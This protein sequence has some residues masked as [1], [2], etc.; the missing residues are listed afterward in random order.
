MQP[1]LCYT[2]TPVLPCLLFL[3]ACSSGKWC[4]PLR[5]H[6]SDANNPW[7]DPDFFLASLRHCKRPSIWT[8][9]LWLPLI[10]KKDTTETD[11]STGPR[12]RH[13]ACR[14]AYRSDSPLASTPIWA[15]S[16]RQRTRPPLPQSILDC[17]LVWRG[18]D[19]MQSCCVTS[20]HAAPSSYV[21]C[22]R[23]RAP[24]FLKIRGTR[25][26]FSF[27]FPFLPNPSRLP[28]LHA[29]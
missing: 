9:G 23:R 2:P 27:L 4:S 24:I 26:L 13:C 1:A 19:L 14:L 29:H 18:F 5:L 17:F 3:L 25:F 16:T 7:C 11:F 21:R 20:D 8:R 22:L 15:Q 6:K 12:D 10:K 28:L